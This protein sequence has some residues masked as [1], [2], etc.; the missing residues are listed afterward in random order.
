MSSSTTPVP[1]WDGPDTNRPGNVRLLVGVRFGG[2]G[3]A[4][5]I[6]H[7]DHGPVQDGRGID[8][9]HLVTATQPCSILSMLHGWLVR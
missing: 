9:L 7:G 8:H 4:P 1:V 2:V 6:P 3:R 5:G